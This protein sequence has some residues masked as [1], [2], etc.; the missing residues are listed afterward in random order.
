M[1][2]HSDIENMFEEIINYYG[3]FGDPIASSFSFKSYNIICTTNNSFE[4]VG[5][6]IGLLVDFS[7]YCDNNCYESAL[8]PCV[9]IVVA[10]INL[11]NKQG[12]VSDQ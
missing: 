11:L 5:A 12:A 8:T 2:L 3:S 9:R 10:S 6:G 4:L 7:V 1:D